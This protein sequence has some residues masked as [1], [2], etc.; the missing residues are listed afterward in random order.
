MHCGGFLTD[1]VTQGVRHKIL[2]FEYFLDKYPSFQGK[3]HLLP[4]PKISFYP[5]TSNRSF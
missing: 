3:V 5:P 2:A 4:S 1:G